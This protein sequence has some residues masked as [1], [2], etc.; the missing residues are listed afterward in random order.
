MNDCVTLEYLPPGQAGTWRTLELMA[1]AVRGEVAPDYSGWRDEQIRRK[2]V[3]VTQGMQ[4]HD[5]DGEVAALFAYVRDR[6]RYRRD[7]VDTERV[8]D[9]A[10]T[11]E[12]NSGDCDDK[13]VLLATL[14]AALGGLPR[15]VVQS[16]D[17]AEF[18]HV[19]LEVF[20]ERSNAWLALDPTA[21]GQAG[22]PLAEVGWRNPARLE[23]RYSIFPEVEMSQQIAGLGELD[24]LDAGNWLRG[25]PGSVYGPAQ[26]G[27]GAAPWW[28]SPINRGIDV[29]GSAVSRQPSIYVSPDDPRYRSGQYGGGNYNY[30][31]YSQNSNQLRITPLGTQVPWWMWVG[32]GLLVGSFLLGKKGR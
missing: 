26:N 28:L 8:Q 29:L 4:G 30:N 7:P 12:A 23:E 1:Q 10:R 9:A 5:F 13:V 22:L 15:F 25:N 2:A 16:Q 24:W 32:A 19:Y 11:L 3:D 20:D 17:G 18:D 21:D 27:S 14:L 6:L 31:P